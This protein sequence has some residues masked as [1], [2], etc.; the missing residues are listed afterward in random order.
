[1]AG[2]EE[3]VSATAALDEAAEEKVL[4]SQVD[5]PVAA[6]EAAAGEVMG[7]AAGIVIVVVELIYLLF[8]LSSSQYFVNYYQCVLFEGQPG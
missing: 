5:M 8:L 3:T 7:E 2:E 4:V 6:G 1:M